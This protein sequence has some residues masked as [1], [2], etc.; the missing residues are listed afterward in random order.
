MALAEEMTIRIMNK[1][2]FGVTV[3]IFSCTDIYII[4]THTVP[5]G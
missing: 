1:F 2:I 3:L 5:L 4:Y